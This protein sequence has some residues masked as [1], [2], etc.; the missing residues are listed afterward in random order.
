VQANLLAATTENVDA[1]NQ[2]Y[3][4]A[5]GE[6]TSLNELFKYLRSNL[7]KYYPHLEDFNARYQDFRIG[8]VRHSLASVE[9]AVA[10]LGYSPKYRV[11]QG[12]AVS[13]DWYRSVFLAPYTDG[14]SQKTDHVT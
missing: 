6:R 10:R 13:I 11:H 4:I 12:L 5:V 3:N 7:A 8:D 2:V 9:K 14:N 1:V